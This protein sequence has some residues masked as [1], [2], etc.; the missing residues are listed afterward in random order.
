MK[1]AFI[2]AGG[3]SK[4]AY[5]IGFCK[6]IKELGLRADIITGTSIGALIGCMLAQDELDKVIELWEQIDVDQVVR[7]GFSLDMNAE[8]LISQRNRVLSFFKQF[9]HDKGADITPLKEMIERLSN[10]DKLMASPV[11]FGLVTVEYPSLNPLQITKSEMEAGRLKDYLIASA[12]CYPAFPVYEIDGKQYV[13]GGYYDNLP[14][15]LAKK[16]GADEFIIVDLN[17]KKVIHEEYLNRPNMRTIIPSRELG[18]FLDFDRQMLDWRIQLGYL[19]TMKA[20]GGYDGYVYTVTV[21]RNDA[22]TV[23]FYNLIVD[24]EAEINA[25]MIRKKVKVFNPQPLTDV[26]RAH[27]RKPVLEIKDYDRAAMEICAQILNIDPDPIYEL[28]ELRKLILSEYEKQHSNT[29]EIIEG[30]QNKNLSALKNIL[31]SLNSKQ[32]MDIL[33]V[34]IQKNDVY[35]MEPRSLFPLVTSEYIAALYVLNLLNK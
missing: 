19:D 34:Q 11:D 13:D 21:R 27:T 4:G 20:F 31:N 18:N 35:M 7:N 26:L 5:E 25:G 9:I 29:D 10:Q 22:L 24:V 15:R 8:A 32:I 28:K 1:R 33:M 6:A 14:V 2:F 17:H 16:M 23:R 12:S 30:L 3:G